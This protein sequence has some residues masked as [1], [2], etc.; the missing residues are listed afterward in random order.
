[1]FFNVTVNHVLSDLRTHGK[2]NFK[3]SCVSHLTTCGVVGSFT[4]TWGLGGQ[5]PFLMPWMKVYHLIPHSHPKSW[6][7]LIPWP[8]E[9]KAETLTAWPPNSW[10]VNIGENVCTFLATRLWEVI[11][12][13]TPST[14]ECGSADPCTRFHIL[15]TTYCLLSSQL[16]LS[17][18][19][20]TSK[21]FVFLMYVVFFF[22]FFPQ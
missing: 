7:D 2:L 21:F 4:G 13:I 8:L 10:K 3:H 9:Y 18:K 17:S 16:L 11:Y 19:E 6:Q 15:S 14:S 1:M 5:M 22:F 20:K 12:W